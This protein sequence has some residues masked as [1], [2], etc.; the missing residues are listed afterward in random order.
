MLL[1]ISTTH[2]PATDLGHLLHKNPAKLHSFEMSF[3]KA[4]LFYPE[5]TSEKCTAALLLDID[6]VGLVRGKRGPGDG[7]TLEQYVNDRPYV[8]SSF[9]SVALGR[10][11]GTAM[12][13][14]SKNRQDLAEQRIPL[15]VGL[16]VVT[17]RRENLLREL[18]EPLGYQVQAKQ[19]P[20]DEKFPEWG[21]SPYF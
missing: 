18:F 7:G 13:G 15:T 6:T 5:A 8:L 9:T 4:H 3:G 17:C 12:T 1:T 2:Q 16:S 11:F 19:L 21:D 14:R 10:I 20:L